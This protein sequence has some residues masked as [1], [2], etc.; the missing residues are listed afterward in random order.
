MGKENFIS[1]SGK[2]EEWR[3]SSG[4]SREVMGV[5]FAE[6]QRR[7]YTFLLTFAGQGLFLSPDTLPFHLAPLKKA[8]RLLAEED[9]HHPHADGNYYGFL[10]VE[11]SDG[12]HLCR[13]DEVPTYTLH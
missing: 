12:E 2:R 9:S 5:G 4:Y 8:C 1:G 6:R 13:F 11:K 7:S 3:L 10:S